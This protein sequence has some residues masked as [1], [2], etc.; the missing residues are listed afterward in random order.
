VPPAV[1]L[2]AFVGGIAAINL[3]LRGRVKRERATFRSEDVGLRLER[4]DPFGL[5]AY[6]FALF[7]RCERAEVANVRS[8]TW[9]ALDV[10]RFD[11]MCTPGGREGARFACAIAPASYALFPLLVESTRLAGLL[12]APALEAVEVEGLEGERWIVRCEDAALAGAVVGPPMVAWL[13]ELDEPWGFEV[14]GSL[15][16]AYG[17]PSA[18]IEEPLVSVEAFARLIEEAGD[19]R[20]GQATGDERPDAAV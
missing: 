8:G 1:V 17:P 12:P 4:G 6:P 18:G 11:L 9:H 2:V 13:S 10:K 19:R 7:G 16:L 15:A 5:I 3:R 20:T 14:N